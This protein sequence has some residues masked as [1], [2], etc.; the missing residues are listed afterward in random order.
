MLTDDDLTTELERA[1]RAETANLTYGGRRRPRRTA[2]LV[3][4]LAAASLALATVALNAHHDGGEPPTAATPAAPS[5]SQAPTP[6][7]L[8]EGRIKL[9]GYTL[10]YQRRAGAPDPLHAQ[11]RL[12]GLPRGVRPV[13]LSG[14]E[15]KA[16]VGK[17]PR[18]GD[19]ALYVKAP[20]RNDGKLFVLL[21]S[22]WSQDQ[23]VNLFRSG[24]PTAVP[25]TRG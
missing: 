22:Q 21:S 20:T 16:W 9:A 15:A 23:L 7:R 2:T 10:S 11:M 12:G 6:P 24:S 5:A 18:S 3:L 14:T 13:P 19:N 1:F 17:D 8:V 25:L 4:P